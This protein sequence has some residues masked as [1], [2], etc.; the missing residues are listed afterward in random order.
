MVRMNKNHRRSVGFVV[1][2]GVLAACSVDTGDVHFVP[3]DVFAIGS[4]DT[5]AGGDV[6]TGGVANIGGV[7]NVAGVL[8]KAGTTGKAGTGNGGS[9][10]TAGVGTGGA[11]LGGA[12]ATAGRGGAAGM[13]GGVNPGQCKLASGN[14]TDTL[15]D[16]LEDGDPKLPMIA[17]REGGWYVSNDGTAGGKQVPAPSMNMPPLPTSPGAPKNGAMSMFAMHTSGSGFESWGANMGITLLQPPG[18]PACPYDVSRHSGV[19]FW[20]RS[21]IMASNVRFAMPTLETHAPAQGG[22]CPERCGD[23]Y[24]VTISPV[25]ATWTQ[26]SVKFADMKQQ[27]FGIATMFYP[28]HVLNVEF[29]VPHSVDFNFWI[30]QLEFF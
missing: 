24:G 13:G 9:S 5:S 8:N 16:D 2:G 22:T 27:N 28:A 12:S 7:A 30:D 11:P 20:I 23:H 26:V 3:D 10:S 18:G 17:G 15:I 6:D 19:R 4:G 14:A 29:S 25:P 1:L 21:D